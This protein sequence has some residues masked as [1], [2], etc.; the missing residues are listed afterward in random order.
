MTT[1]PN[2]KALSEAGVSIWLDDLSRQRISSGNLAELI[3]DQAVV[4]V[5]SNPTI[6]ANALSNAADY[7]EK[8]RE[9]AARGASVDDT[10]R[11]LTTADV[12]DAAD[13]FRNV[14]ESTG[15]VD[16]R[17]SLEV[18][19]RLAHDTDRTVAEA[20]ELWKA[21]DRPNLMVK[22]PATLAGLPAITRVLAEGI[23]VNVTLIFSV[24]RYR[25]VMDA[26]LAGLEQAKAN[27]HDLAQISSV[28]SFFVSR[29]DTE[30]D[31]RLAKI[32]G[33][34]ELRGKAAIANARL[35]Y[36]AYLDV[37]ASERWQAL[38]ADGARAQRPLWASTGVKDPAY[39]DTRYV[40]ELVA[41]NTVNT[42]PEAT[43]KATADHADVRGDLVTGTAAASQQ[44]FDDLAKI[45]I[46]LD[47][48]FAVLESEGV[49]KFEKSWTELLE[50]VGQQLAQAE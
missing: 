27:G 20:I 6:F 41:P 39:S 28:A 47:D 36:A 29:V 35:A 18:D 13:I 46:D 45:G 33:G 9:L 12:R 40:D 50:T 31:K 15:R 30:I 37:F 17:V 49:E 8:V 44:V 7:N 2:L 48:V 3:T 26:F 38:A 42:M 23:S 24:Q 32:E 19:P 10:V 43:L 21:V 22:I 5:T 34:E 25:D 16:G 14:Y 4:G 11:E 1:N